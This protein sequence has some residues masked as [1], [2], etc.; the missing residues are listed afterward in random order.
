MKINAKNSEKKFDFQSDK[1]FY[2]IQGLKSGSA[3]S[4]GLPE[5]RPEHSI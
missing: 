2:R 1:K 5:S 4:I 3:W